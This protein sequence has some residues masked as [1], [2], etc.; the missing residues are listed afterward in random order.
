MKPTAPFR[1]LALMLIFLFVACE[2]KPEPVTPPLIGRQTATVTLRPT[3]TFSPTPSPTPTTTPRPT[4][5]NTAVPTLTPTP[6][7]TIPVVEVGTPVHP[8][9][10]VIVPEN[11]TQLT[12]LARW[13][14]GVINDVAYSAD[15]NWIAV[16][17]SRG[18]YV[19]DVRDF[20]AEPRHIETGGVDRVAISPD[21]GLVAAALFSLPI[22]TVMMKSMSCMPMEAMSPG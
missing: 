7:P 15:G 8:A 10:A 11:V 17:T 1:Y 20:Q 9:Q 18:I 4:A 16:G 3:A 21:G 14:R 6:S 5:T 13:G 22:V 12:E 19:H 2:Q